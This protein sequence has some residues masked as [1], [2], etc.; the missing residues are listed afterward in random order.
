MKSF[1]VNDL[2]VVRGIVQ[3]SSTFLTIIVTM[4]RTST[5]RTVEATVTSFTILNLLKSVKIDI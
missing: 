2:I 5:G 3:D 4:H 1:Y